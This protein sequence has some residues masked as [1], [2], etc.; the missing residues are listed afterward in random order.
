M[1]S[2]IMTVETSLSELIV[3]T[4]RKGSN[5]RAR[6]KSL[7]ASTRHSDRRRIKSG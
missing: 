6:R 4:S 5:A 1:L 7:R 3:M 2:V